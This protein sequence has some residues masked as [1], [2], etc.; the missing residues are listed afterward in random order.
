MGGNQGSFQVLA[1]TR[2]DAVN[3]LTEISLGKKKVVVRRNA[4]ECSSWVIAQACLG[5]KETAKQFF[6]VAES[7]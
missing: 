6:T 5:F 4:P 7:F 1:I 2:K 3:I